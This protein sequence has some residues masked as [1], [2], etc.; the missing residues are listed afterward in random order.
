MANKM[1]GA[2]SFLMIFKELYTQAIISQGSGVLGIFL[3][4]DT[5]TE[6]EKKTYFNISDVSSDDWNEKNYKY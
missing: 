3:V 5:S 2:V 4:D 1:N 6:F